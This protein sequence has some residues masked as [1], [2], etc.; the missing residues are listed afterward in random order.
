MHILPHIF[1]NLY[2]SSL[3]SFPGPPSFPPYPVSP[4]D[5]TISNGKLRRGRG[6]GTRLY[7][8]HVGRGKKG[9]SIWNFEFVGTGVYVNII[10]LVLC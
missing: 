6:L 9:S 7:P 2:V 1:S 3:A 10:R 4:L 8:G 5:H